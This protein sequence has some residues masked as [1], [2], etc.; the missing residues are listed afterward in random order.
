MVDHL[1]IRSRSR[2]IST[3]NFGQKKEVKGHF[4]YFPHKIGK[5]KVMKFGRFNLLVSLVKNLKF[6]EN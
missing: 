1:I 4:T 3:Q 2:D 5:A 6:H